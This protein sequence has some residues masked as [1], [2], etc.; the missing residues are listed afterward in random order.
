MYHDAS[1]MMRMHD[2][3]IMM[4][5]SILRIYDACFNDAFSRMHVYMMHISLMHVSIM[6][7]FM[8]HLRIMHMSKT[9]DPDACMMHIST[10]D[11]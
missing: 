8:M 4:L 10:Y 3:C 6:H 7:V 9:L 5:L 1:T 2:A 11:T